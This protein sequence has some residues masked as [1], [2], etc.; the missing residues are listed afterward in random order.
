MKIN[1]LRWVGGGEMLE[2]IQ[3]LTNVR[4]HLNPLFPTLNGGKETAGRDLQAAPT[5][6]RPSF[7]PWVANV[8]LMGL[9]H[10]TAQRILC[11]FFFF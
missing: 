3:I 5:C 6:R 2:G 11:S 4:G 10:P 1:P 8:S 9:D 7:P